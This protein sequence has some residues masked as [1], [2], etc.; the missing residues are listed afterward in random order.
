M[1]AKEKKKYSADWRQGLTDLYFYDQLS[2]QG[3]F[4]PIGMQTGFS[5][6]LDAIKSVNTSTPIFP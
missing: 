4:D 5:I 2:S 1:I 6:H 3:A